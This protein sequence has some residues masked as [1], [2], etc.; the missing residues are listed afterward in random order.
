MKTNVISLGPITVGALGNGCWSYG[1]GAYWG[2]QPQ[3]DVNEVVAR[4]LE[5][6]MNFFDTA[7]G[8]NDG[9][10]EVALGVALRGKRE[11]AVIG[12]KVSPSH[13][14]PDLLRR[15]CEN[16][17][18]RLG[19]EFIDLYMMHWPI[20]TAD[21]AGKPGESSALTAA[22]FGEMLRLKEEGKIREIGVS[23]YGVRQ[24]GELF[25]L[26]V[27]VAVNQLSY[28]L[29]SRAI[30]H[31]ILPLCR[32]RNISVLGYSALMQGLL[33]GKYE[34]ASDIP[35]NFA[36]T[37]HFN[38]STAGAASRHG[39]EGCEALM[40]EA[41]D[42]IRSLAAELGQ[43]TASLSLAWAMSKEGVACTIVGN[44]SL[45]QLAENAKSSSFELSVDVR[46]RLD[47]L[48][49]PVWRALGNNPDYY[50]SKNESRTR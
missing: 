31:E 2:E 6:G 27:P 14:R 8:Y 12:T 50:V 9:Q 19:T 33:S 11:Q 20:D 4:S 32:S 25:E 40:F 47:E 43:S 36:R 17:L 22:A 28:N 3:R 24:L 5:L 35:A 49:L 38:H 26:G 29:F 34:K 16:S 15:S 46:A 7:E 23:N 30:E 44:R 37:R 1:G 48:T 39:E 21:P 13:A 42:G 10:S 45:A 41:L 18:R